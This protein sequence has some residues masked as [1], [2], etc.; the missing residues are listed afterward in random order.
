MKKT[1][2]FAATMLAVATAAQAADQPKDEF[3]WNHSQENTLTWEAGETIR[4]NPGTT[5]HSTDTSNEY[6]YASIRVKGAGADQVAKGTIKGDVLAFTAKTQTPT[7]TTDGTAYNAIVLAGN[8]A[9]TID[10]KELRIG[11]QVKDDTTGLK[12]ADRGIRLT[13]ANN[14]LNLFADKIV[15][16]TGDEFVHVRNGRAD[17]SANSVANIGS[18]ERRIGYFEAHTGWGKD[19]Y[20]VAILQANEGGTINFYAEEAL[21]DGSTNIDGGVFGS[22]SDGTVI[23][24]ANKLTIDGNICGTYGTVKKEGTLFID[25]TTKDLQAT[26]NVNAGSRDEG[27]SKH[28]RTTYVNVKAESGKLKGDIN[29]FKQGNVALYSANGLDFEGN[30]VGAGTGRVILGG[31]QDKEG[32]LTA[33]G[34]TINMTGNV[35]LKDTS[36]LIVAGMLN[37]EDTVVTL[38]GTTVE[39]PAST[40]LAVSPYGS[41][42]VA[43]RFEMMKG[44]VAKVKSVS[45]A[46][47]TVTLDEGSILSVKEDTTIGT[48]QATNGTLHVTEAADAT[49]GSVSGSAVMK[50]DSVDNKITVTQTLAQGSSIEAV[51]SSVFNESFASAEEALKAAAGTIS[52]GGSASGADGIE[53]TIE[54]S[55]S[56]GAASGVIDETGKIDESTIVKTVNTKTERVGKTI[57]QNVL[58]WRLEMNDMNK[59]L[60]ELRDS[61]GNTGLWARV[62]AGEQRFQGSDND[63]VTLQM[64]ADTKI[65][66]AANTHVGAAFSYTKSDLS[67]TGGD[68]DNEIYGL[69]AYASWLGEKGSFLD[70]VAKVARLESDSKIDGT[71]ADFDTTAYS[72]SAE[73]GHRFDVTNL[74]FV[75]PQM[76]LSYGYVSGETFDTKNLTTAQRTKTEL[77]GTD[78]LIGRVG[79]RAGVSCPEKKGNVYVRASLLREFQGDITV[80]R[81]DGAYELET[82]DTW[83]EYGIGGNYNVTPTTQIYADVERNTGADLSEPWRFNIGA[84]WAF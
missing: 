38:E 76:E 19:D 12:G 7:T 24:D 31:V 48:L 79:F 22:G 46:D 44:A 42:P 51:G 34:G 6:G 56:N 36:T 3:D 13:G 68:G 30:V 81:G 77:D 16:Y 5:D 40:V 53:V 65:P 35:S 62:N 10:V 71:R 52:V 20:G 15:S 41:E 11:D 18:A 4:F 61:E 59:R 78:S 73:I 8:S 55:E 2:L 75:E 82:D 58:A 80:S 21:F 32:K 72:L 50:F 74:V 23:V 9:L 67:Y 45:A 25:V 84:R 17:N 39:Q 69:A 37:A 63:F 70:V 29:V 1:M 47:E 60:G 64:G 14:T 54:E 83:F 49:L 27:Y 57:A 43:G 33:T 28:G 26:G 66:A